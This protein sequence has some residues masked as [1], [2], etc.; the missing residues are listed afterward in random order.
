MRRDRGLDRAVD[1]TGLAPAFQPIVD[2]DSGDTVGL[3][4]LARWSAPSGIGPHEVFSHAAAMGQTAQLDQRCAHAAITL[5]LDSDIAR[6][7]LLTV[8]YEPATPYPGRLDGALLGRAAD[9]LTLAFELTER[10][11][12]TH[13]HTVLATV[14][15]MR[16]DGFLIALDDVGA[17]P[18]SL[19]LLDVVRPD[20]IKLD[21]G[22]V[23]QQ[24]RTVQARTIAAVLAYHERAGT[25]ILAEGIENDIHLEHARALG[26][27]L[28]QGFK[29]GH[30]GPIDTFAPSSAAA[31]VSSSPSRQSVAA[32]F[33]VAQRSSVRSR[34]SRKQI[35]TAL[36]NHI[37]AQATYTADPPI[38]LAALQHRNHLDAATLA[39]YTQLA[40][41]SPLVAIFG[42]GLSPDLG[43][44]VRGVALH[45]DDPLRMEWTVV[46]LGPQL[47]VALIARELAG[48][49]VVAQ[50]DRRFE[51]IL[52]YE[53][54][55]V[56]E[57]AHNLLARMS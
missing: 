10:G 22:L 41:S 34:L 27:C 29:Y 5:A 36:S 43:G 47:A 51:F 4:A 54:T 55:L 26:A 14:D 8:N 46:A 52:T 1:G 17:H 53:R 3:E 50:A 56:T 48:D 11:L 28:G 15:A 19:A 13:P 20:I 2:L 42:E 35:L 30:A 23:Q 24:P 38:V 6:G 37:E 40:E 18:D 7:T 44:K 49:D 16:G 31:L 33:D 9:E 32:P 25:P 39:R 57:A 12:L 45:R 21:M